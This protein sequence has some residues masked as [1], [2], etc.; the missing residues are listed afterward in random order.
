MDKKQ[1]GME[2]KNTA[3][4]DIPLGMSFRWWTIR[5]LSLRSKKTCSF[6]NLWVLVPAYNNKKTP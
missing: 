4:K 3:K 5:R 1:G 6:P 2:E